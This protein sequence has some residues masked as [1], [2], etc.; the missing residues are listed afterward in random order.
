MR[1]NDAARWLSR[2]GNSSSWRVTVRTGRSCRSH[3]PG[4][5]PSS[6]T[7][8]ALGGAKPDGR[9]GDGTTIGRSVP[10]HQRGLH[11]HQRRPSAGLRCGHG[12][13]DALLGGNSNGG[14]G[15]GTT[16]DV[17]TPVRVAGQ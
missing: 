16:T 9:P 5:T 4:R 3:C 8:C 11:R 7:S 12:P 17:T 2:L 13:A 6:R 14:L 1:T 15:N 10:A